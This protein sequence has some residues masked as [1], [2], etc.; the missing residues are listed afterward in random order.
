MYQFICTLLLY[1]CKLFRLIEVR[2]KQHIP[3]NQRF[4]VTCSHVGWLDVIM[5]AVAIHPTPINYMAK[6]E[7]FV[8]SF[9]NKFLRS[10]KAFP[11]NRENPGPSALKIPMKLLKENKC[12]GIFPSG[13]RTREDVPLK[14]GAVTI[15]FKS[16]APLLPAVYQGPSTIKELLNGQKAVVTFGEPI[17]FEQEL[18]LVKREEQIDKGVELLEEKMKQ[19]L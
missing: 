19:L 9:A 7:L 17:Y 2:G 14:K 5:L 3:S 1:I 4:V 6:K 15:A 8:R 13:T 11:V 12:V 18:Q 16:K 10:V